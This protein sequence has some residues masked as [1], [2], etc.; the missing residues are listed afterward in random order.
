MRK[1]LIEELGE[2]AARCLSMENQGPQ[3]RREWWIRSA[4]VLADRP[5]A[6]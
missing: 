1:T 3:S 5:F 4:A 2:R 6:A